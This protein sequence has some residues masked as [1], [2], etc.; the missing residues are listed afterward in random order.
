[1]LAALIRFCVREPLIVLLLTAALIG[2]GVY[3]VRVTV[4]DGPH[5]GG[6]DGVASLGVRPMFGGHVAN[7]ETHILDFGGDLYGA[8]VSTGLVD[9]RRD[10]MRFDDVDALIEQIKADEADA[11]RILSAR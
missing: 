7:L 10:E 2:F 1:M 6:Y 9:W 3:A 5:A 11:R 4:K 8:R